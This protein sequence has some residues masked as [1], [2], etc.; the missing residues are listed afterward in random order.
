MVS[1]EAGGGLPFAARFTAP[2]PLLEQQH[3]TTQQQ[4]QPQEEEEV[5]GPSG[6]GGVLQSRVLL[7]D[8]SVC[9]RLFAGHDFPHLHQHQQH[10]DDD[11]EASS[12]WEEGIDLR[13]HPYHHRTSS[14]ASG[15]H[16]R[17]GAEAG[18]RDVNVMVEVCL[19]HVALRADSLLPPD[20]NT[21]PTVSTTSSQEQQQQE[22]EGRQQGGSQGGGGG[23]MAVVSSWLV[24]AVKD[25]HV[26]DRISTAQQRKVL[27]YWYVPPI[28]PALPCPRLTDPGHWGGLA[29]AMGVCRGCQAV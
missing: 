21:P 18:G 12:F 27:G 16:G 23:N 7:H 14:R 20:N 8:L 3:N 10:D 26:S 29:G 15:S 13:H 2:S 9:W 17:G 19:S 5:K 6:G 25:L 24:L 28:S 4:P 11:D 22:E 1:E